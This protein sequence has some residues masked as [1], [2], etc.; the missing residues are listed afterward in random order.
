MAFDV[1]PVG[2]NSGFSEESSIDSEKDREIVS[3]GGRI[4]NFVVAPFSNDDFGI[5]TS[6][7]SLDVD[8]APGTAFM[9]GHRVVS[10]A[11]VTLTLDASS[12]NHIWLVVRDGEAGNATVEYNTDGS[13]P[14]GLYATKLWEVTTDSS[15]VTGTT[16]TRRYVPYPNLDPA[17]SITGLKATL[18]GSPATPSVS[19]ASTG[20]KTV[21]VTF[22]RSYREEIFAVVASL[23][24]LDDTAASFGWIRTKNVTVDGF[25]IE[26][27][28]DKQGGSGT[29][30]DFSWTAQGR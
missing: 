5:T 19:T 17:E 2:A 9:G 4:T 26:A 28:V 15:G 21:D 10:D 11:T 29:T 12:T 7:S 30:A 14:S 13:T 18:Q 27:K 22:D 16:D 6:G 20:V 3:L 24:N 1:Y 25:T 23:N 8:V